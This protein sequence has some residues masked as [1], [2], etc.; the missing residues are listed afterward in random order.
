MRKKNTTIR[1]KKKMKKEM[2]K[3]QGE[4]DKGKD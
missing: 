3:G 4:I 1:D 2:A